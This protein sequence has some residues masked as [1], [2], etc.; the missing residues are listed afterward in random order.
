VTAKNEDVKRVAVW[1]RR[2]ST[3][4]EEWG[5]LW[6]LYSLTFR[7]EFFSETKLPVFGL[8]RNSQGIERAGV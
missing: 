8:L 2:A 5:L 4:R 1:R 6:F 7:E 3:Y